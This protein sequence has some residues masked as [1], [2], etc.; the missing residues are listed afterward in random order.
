MK[1]VP[2]IPIMATHT[3]V[4]LILLWTQT[5]TEHKGPGGTP[6]VEVIGILVGNFFGKP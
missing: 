4:A 2:K 5:L 3:T 1:E 6:N